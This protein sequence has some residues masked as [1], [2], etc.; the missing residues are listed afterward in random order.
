MSTQT[1]SI[2]EAASAPRLSRTEARSA[3]GRDSG[4]EVRYAPAEVEVAAKPTRRRFSADYRLRIL[5]EVDRTTTRGEIGRILRREGLYA[6]HLTSWRKARRDG[7]MAALEPKKRGAKAKERNPLVPVV[8][9]LEAKVHRLERELERA[10]II[11]GVQEK[12][13]GLLGLD[14]ERGK[15]S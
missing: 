13:A 3:G 10:Q 4:A 8:A 7:S 12:V 2:H 11:I 15:S 9:G 14:L 5:E 1:D 6:S